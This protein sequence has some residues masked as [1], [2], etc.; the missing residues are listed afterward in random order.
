[1]PS[2]FKPQ[3]RKA[4]EQLDLVLVARPPVQWIAV[5]APHRSKSSLAEVVIQS[6]RLLMLDWSKCSAVARSAGNVSDAWLGPGTRVP[7]AALFDN[8]SQAIVA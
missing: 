4:R 7:V 8:V 6:Y 3:W 2:I 1:M 5:L